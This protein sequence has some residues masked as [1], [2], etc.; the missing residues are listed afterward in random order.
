MKLCADTISDLLPEDSLFA[1]KLLVEDCV[2]STNTQLKAMAAAGAPEGTILLAEEQTGGRGT[3][4]RSFCSPR[5]EGLY[6]SVLLRPRAELSDLVQ[7][8]GWVAVAARRAVERACGA[9]AQIKW[10]NDLYLN[11]RKLC[12]ILTELSLNSDNRPAHV[13]VGIGVNVSQTADTFRAQGLE[14]I[15]TSLAAEG[16]SVDRNRLCACLLEELD[17]MYRLFPDGQSVYLEEYRKFC[18]TP[19]REVTFEEGGQTLRGSALSVDD[20]FG[21]VVRGEDGSRRTVFT[22]TVS[23]V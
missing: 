15:A 20:E 5:G 16:Y 9:P 18:L 2:D 22:G 3:R 23:L 7:L 19:G 21:L 17:M 1:G 8:T 4:G 10:L 13:V 12:G 14:G 11:G 6:L